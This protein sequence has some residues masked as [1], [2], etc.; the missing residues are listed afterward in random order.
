MA[1]KCTIAEKEWRIDQF[2]RLIANG[3]VYSDLVRYAAVEWG[4]SSR[5]A[6]KYITWARQK[7]VEDI[8]RERPLVVAEM[9]AVCQS[10]IRKGMKGDNLNAVLGAVNTIA[11]LGGLEAQKP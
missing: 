9:M 6:D 3:A 10:V 5:T 2:V 8:D 7:I 1:K 11:R 4:V